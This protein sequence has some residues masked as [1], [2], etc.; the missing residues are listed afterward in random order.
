MR[1][2]S[3]LS[4][5]EQKEIEKQYAQGK[6]PGDIAPAYGLKPKQISDQAY[7]KKWTR[8]G[9]ARKK[10]TV[11]NAVKKKKAAGKK[12]AG[13]KKAAKKKAGK[14]KAAKKKTAKKKATKK[15]R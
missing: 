1:H 11:K 15:R 12:K 7:R 4:E 13:K 9:M 2:W 5:K 6:E 8:P 14:K 10:A 3:D